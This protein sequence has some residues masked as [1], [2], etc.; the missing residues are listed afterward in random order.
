MQGSLTAHSLPRLA[1]TVVRI[2]FTRFEEEKDCSLSFESM[3]G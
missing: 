2:E 3:R 1:W